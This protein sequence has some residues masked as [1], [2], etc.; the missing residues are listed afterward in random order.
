MDK[1]MRLPKVMETVGLS[2]STIYNEI[3]KGRFP[4]PIRLSPRTSGW[5]LSDIEE[6][7][8]RKAEAG[9]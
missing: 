2:R 7:M 8:K 9:R 4:G 6:W 5:R 1:V 3:S